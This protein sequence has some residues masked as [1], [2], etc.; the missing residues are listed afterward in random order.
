MVGHSR[1]G[2]SHSKVASQLSHKSHNKVARMVGH[3]RVGRSH[4]QLRGHNRGHKFRRLCNW[5]EDRGVHM[6]KLT[7]TLST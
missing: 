7:H 5:T 2:R 1:V 6:L 3:S 4:S